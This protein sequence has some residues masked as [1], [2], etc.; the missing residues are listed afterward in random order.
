MKKSILLILL[1]AGLSQCSPQQPAT[2]AQ[3]ASAKIELNFNPDDIVAI[4]YDDD[5]MREARAAYQAKD[6]T[7]MKLFT[8][9]QKSIEDAYLYTDVV[10]VTDNTKHYAPSRDPREHVTLSPYWFKD[11]D[12]EDGLPY[13]RS[14]GV[15]NPERMEYSARVLGPI[16]YL[17]SENLAF[18]YYV[19]QDEKY[20]A[21][22]ADYIRAWFLDPEKGLNPN[23]V[24]AQYVP[25]MQR[26][27]GTGVIESRD[28]T[29]AI[30][31]AKMISE[32]ESWTD[33]DDAEFKDWARAY[34]YWMEYS[35]H[36]QEEAR[37]ANNHAMW[38]EVNREALALY[39]ED[40]EHLAKM[41][42][43]DLYPRLAEQIAADSTMP[44]EIA[45]TLGLNY[46]TF[47]LSAVAQTSI[48]ASKIGITDIW[49]YEGAN[50]RGM[51][52]GLDFIIPYWKAP[53]TWP[54]MQIHAHGEATMPTIL[55][56]AYKSTKD[57]KYN[58][59]L[60][61]FRSP[62]MVNNNIATIL[63]YKLEK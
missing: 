38:Y 19:T 41:V 3:T 6:P 50:G 9:Y 47:T 31:A 45:R 46:T 21:K 7:F 52:W 35:T 23:L 48:M 5:L 16:M 49:T 34:L 24:F 25:G 33:K 30:S 1:A 62:G 36:G 37:S 13:I 14:D 29:S 60:H 58:E 28:I 10:S 27:R 43:E 8:P 56:Q 51:K 12:T 18:L 53:E 57:E 26:I 17:G 40:Y 22:A 4:R 44:H 54:Y 39:I 32:S 2:T 15:G 59:M 55:H 42:R 20:A 11:P 61:N 63:F